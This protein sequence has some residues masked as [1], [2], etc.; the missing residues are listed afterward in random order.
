MFLLQGQCYKE[1]PLVVET[2][3]FTIESLA[4]QDRHLNGALSIWD[5]KRAWLSIKLYKIILL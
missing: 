1:T 2:I 4:F 5:I 3:N